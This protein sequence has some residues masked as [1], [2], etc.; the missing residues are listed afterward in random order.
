MATGPNTTGWNTPATVSTIALDLMLRVSKVIDRVIT[1]VQSPT[2]PSRSC[3]EAV[4]VQDR[5]HF[6]ITTRTP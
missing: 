4:V 2:P 3:L 5:S 6:G 1:T